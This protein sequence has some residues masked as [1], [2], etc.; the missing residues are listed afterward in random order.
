MS[1]ETSKKEI[2]DWISTLEDESVLL[3]L[4]GIKRNATFNFDEEVKKGIPLEE[5]RDEMIKRV[6]NY[7]WKK[8]G[9][10]SE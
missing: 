6:R 3:T 8:N 4:E 5:F 9:T 7:P 10:V 1:T 2:I